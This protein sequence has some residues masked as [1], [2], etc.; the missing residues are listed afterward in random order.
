MGLDAVLTVI[1]AA[2]YRKYRANPQHHVPPTRGEFELYREWFWLDAALNKMKAPLHFALRGNRPEGASWDEDWGGAYFAFATVGFVKKIDKS[3]A[4]VSKN[5]FLT[6]L[7][8]AGSRL[9]KYEQ[10]ACYGALKTLKAA[11]RAAAKNNACLV[12]LIC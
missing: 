9:R 2:E 6:A 10:E 4:K 3:F 8:V 1:P 7:K 12:I 11:Y 5:E